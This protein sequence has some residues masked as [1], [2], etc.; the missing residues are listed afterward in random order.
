VGAGSAGGLA[1]I[2]AA[3]VGAGQ[4]PAFERGG[5]SVAVVFASSDFPARSRTLR[6]FS[7]AG[8]ALGTLV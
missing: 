8:W 5:D 6:R 3:F 7:T 4:F 1:G 2:A